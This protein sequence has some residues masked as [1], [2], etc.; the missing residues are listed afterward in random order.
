M[1]GHSAKITMN[2]PDRRNALDHQLLGDKEEV[3]HVIKSLSYTQS[4]VQKLSKGN[5]KEKQK[6]IINRKEFIR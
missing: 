1:K 6:F 4:K 5:E 3:L 2:P